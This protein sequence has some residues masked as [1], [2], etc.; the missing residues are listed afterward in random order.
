MSA[1]IGS[2][3]RLGDDAAI[4]CDVAMVRSCAI[5]SQAGLVVTVWVLLQVSS[6]GD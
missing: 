2:R 1:A 5:E 3:A 4:G 6:E